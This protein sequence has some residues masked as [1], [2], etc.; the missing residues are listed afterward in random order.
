MLVTQSL[1]VLQ[2]ALSSIS[3]ELRGELVVRLADFPL[4]VFSSLFSQPPRFDIGLH[5]PQEP[6]S[7]LVRTHPCRFKEDD[8]VALDQ[9]SD[10][11]HVDD[12][13]GSTG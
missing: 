3:F 6:I 5:M 12:D 8:H 9:R 2:H 1:A 7:E 4:C 10:V 11:Q 13:G